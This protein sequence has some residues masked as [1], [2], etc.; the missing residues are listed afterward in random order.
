MCMYAYMYIYVIIYICTAIPIH[1]CTYIQVYLLV[2]A[3][4]G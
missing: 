4:A 2:V 3:M 1:H